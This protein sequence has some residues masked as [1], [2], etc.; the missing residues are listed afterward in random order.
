M[1]DF[2]SL[3]NLYFSRINNFKNLLRFAQGIICI[4]KRSNIFY[5][6]ESAKLCTPIDN[7]VAVSIQYMP[8]TL[9]ETISQTHAAK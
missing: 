6:F 9:A 8:S 7:G 1:L 4:R 2:L 3:V 5:V